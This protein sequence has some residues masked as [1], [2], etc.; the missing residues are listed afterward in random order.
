[1]DV[2]RHKRYYWRH[3]DRCVA[4]A[5]E[6][7]NT[8][9]EQKRAYDREYYLKNKLRINLRHERNALA[10][11]EHDLARKRDYRRRRKAN[12]GFPLRMKGQ[13]REP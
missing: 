8:H 10:N 12:G 11:R 2:S 9:K 7:R 3:H 6:Y 13:R 5:R 1:M 4:K